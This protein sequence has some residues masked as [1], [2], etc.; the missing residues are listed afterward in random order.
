MLFKVPDYISNLLNRLRIFLV[1]RNSFSNKILI[2]LPAF[3]NY[4]SQI[5]GYPLCWGLGVQWERNKYFL[6][7]KAGTEHLIAVKCGESCGNES[8]EI[9]G[10]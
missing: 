4:V 9:Y 8:T 5:R 10:R 3:L 1:L 7:G 2:L 6:V